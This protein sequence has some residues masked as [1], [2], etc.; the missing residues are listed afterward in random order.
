VQGLDPLDELGR[1]INYGGNVLLPYITRVQEYGNRVGQ[2]I[3][4]ELLHTD[5]TATWQARHNVWLD[6]KL[7]VRHTNLYGTETLP[8]VSLRW[9]APQRLH[10]F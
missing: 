1:P 2:G 5:F 4:Y 7:I 6:A 10:E 3:R 9:N 8:S